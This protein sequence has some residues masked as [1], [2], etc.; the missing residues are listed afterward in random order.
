M[1]QTGAISRSSLLFF[2][3]ILQ[4][5]A[6]ADFGCPPRLI[7]AAKATIASRPDPRAV[8]LARSGAITGGL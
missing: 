7:A 6:V 1:E 4:T 8:K 5:A 3:K 2:A